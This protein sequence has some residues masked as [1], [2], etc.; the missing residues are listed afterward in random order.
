MFHVSVSICESRTVV[1]ISIFIKVLYPVPAATSHWFLLAIWSKL[2]WSIHYKNLA[3]LL[4]LAVFFNVFKHRQRCAGTMLTLPLKS[5]TEDSGWRYC[6]V[7]EMGFSPEGRCSGFE[8]GA[9]GGVQ[10]GAVARTMWSQ[11]QVGQRHLAGRWW[12][13]RGW[14]AGSGWTRCWLGRERWRYENTCLWMSLI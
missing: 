14:W 11:E 8:G 1:I 2:S 6:R 13:G 5:A 3:C 10:R 12:G 7:W 4:N 9:C